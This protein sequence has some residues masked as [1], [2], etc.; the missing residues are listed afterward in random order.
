MVFLI[1]IAAVVSADLWFKNWIIANIIPGTWKAFLPGVLRLTLVHNF[2]AAFSIMQNMRWLF[3]AA[4]LVLIAAAVWA[5]LKK[6]VTYP[7]ARWSLSAVVAG[8]IGNCI[9]RIRFGYVV[10]MFETEF[11]SFPVFNIADCFITVGGIIFCIYLFF[12]YEKKELGR[13]PDK[14]KNDEK[15][16]D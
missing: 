12:F 10:D 9:D 7:L 3:V 2:G 6:K 11:M 13:L 5:F 15:T 16:D 4:T 1:F 8:A 14:G